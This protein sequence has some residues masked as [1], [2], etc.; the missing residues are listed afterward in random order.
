MLYCVPQERVELSLF[1]SVRGISIIVD[2]EEW[3]VFT[4]I[5]D[6]TPL[7]CTPQPDDVKCVKNEM[8]ILLTYVDQENERKQHVLKCASMYL[9]KKLVVLISRC[10]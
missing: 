9:I 1:I 6:S 7:P 10:G 3:G 5:D 4:I 2:F 8:S